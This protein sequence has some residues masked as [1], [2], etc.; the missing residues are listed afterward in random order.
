MADGIGI[1]KSTIQ[2]VWTTFGLQ[3]HREE[4]FKISTDPFF[5]K[6]IRDIVGLYLT[7]PTQRY[8]AVR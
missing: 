7:P 6:K 3:P 8:C 2:R 1:S 5:I 4:H